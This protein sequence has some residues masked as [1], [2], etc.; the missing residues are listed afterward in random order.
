MKKLVYLIYIIVLSIILLAVGCKTSD[1]TSVWKSENM[2]GRNFNKIMVV[3]I[4]SADD[5][6]LGECME[7]HMVDDLKRL[8]YPAVSASAKYGAKKFQGLDEQQIMEKLAKEGVDAIITVGLLARHVQKADVPGYKKLVPY[9]AYSEH[10][11]GYYNSTYSRI[12][13][14]GYY[15][16][17]TE[18]FWEGNFYE[19]LSRDLQYAIQTESFEPAASQMLVHHYSEAMVHR[20]LEDGVL[21]SRPLIAGVRSAK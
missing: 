18:F 20:M 15:E 9:A 14:P 4:V 2:T 21:S 12:E 16:R 5:Y 3:S 17:S 13:T 7:T 6:F 10:F 19:V 11:W 1:I 8:G